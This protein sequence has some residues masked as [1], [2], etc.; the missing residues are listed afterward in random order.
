MAEKVEHNFVADALNYEQRVR[1]ELEVAKRWYEE[2]GVLYCPEEPR[3]YQTRVDML[4][5]KSQ[6]IPN[7]SY[8]TTSQEY[9]VGK[10]LPDITPKKYKG[11]TKNPIDIIMMQKKMKWAE[12]EREKAKTIAKA[13]GL[14]TPE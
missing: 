2:W 14:L 9:G 1:S 6:E 11:S 5:K 4:T 3:C 12:E 8:K 13:R 7:H 10:P